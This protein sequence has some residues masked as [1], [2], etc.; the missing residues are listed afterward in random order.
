MPA[1]R[2]RSDGV[3]PSR[4]Q[5]PGRMA[6]PRRLRVYQTKREFGKTPEPEGKSGA[7]LAAS[8][9]SARPRFTVQKHDATRLHYDLRLEVDGVLASWAVPKGPSLDPAN[10]RLAVRTEDHPLEYLTFEGVIPEGQYGAGRMIVWDTGTYESI[11]QDSRGHPIAMAKALEQGAVKVRFDGRR[12]KGA[13]SLVRSGGRSPAAGKEQWLLIKV[14]DD[15]ADAGADLLGD[16]PESV[17]T[18]RTIDDLG[19][20]TR[21]SR[22]TAGLESRVGKRPAKAAARTADAGDSRPDWIAPMLATLIEPAGRG[23][24]LGDEWIYEHKYDG[25]RALAFRDGDSIRLLSR[26]AK[27]LAD[28]FPEIVEALARQPLKD[29]VI[30]GEIVALSR[31][32]AGERPSFSALQQRLKATTLAG[33]RRRGITLRFYVFDLLYAAGRDS[34]S[35]PFARRAD[36][37][38]KAIRESELIQISRRFSG[39]AQTLLAQACRDG[40]EGLI[41]KRA[42]DPYISGRS[43][44]WL[45]LKCSLRQE[46]VIGGWTDPQGSRTALGSL[47]LGYYDQAGGTKRKLQYAGRV[48]TGFSDALLRD[49]LARLRSRARKTSPFTANPEVPRRGVHFTSPQL[50]CEVG[51]AEWTHDD[52]IRHPRFLGL[53]EDKDAS[54][55]VREEPARG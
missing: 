35:V 30:D 37:L 42:S 8:A 17:V 41:A 10:K 49:L 21:T 15:A 27:S 39:D 5:T 2:G 20:R 16:R 52:H 32:A 45:K 25:F 54:E 13:Y 11:K 31:H 33:A 22:G 36:L 38:G 51:F 12:L 26:N 23:A 3:D 24:A 28:R 48:G 6:R 9:R 44:S 1:R 29:F 53:R 14:P 18:G 55:V 46:F 47:L 7:A 50:V 34:R 19:P 43:R 4:R 40:W